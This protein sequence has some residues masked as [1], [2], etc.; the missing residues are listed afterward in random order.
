[1]EN[2]EYCTPTKLVF[3]KDCINSLPEVLEKLGKNVLLAYGGGSIKRSGLY[4]K[5]QILL[6]GFNVVELAG[7][8]PNPRYNPSVLKG[9][10]LCRENNVDVILAAGGGSVIDCAKAIAG[11]AG[12]EGDAWDII[13]GKIPTT[14]AIPIVDILTLAATGSEY[15]PGAV[16]SKTETND[17]I[18]YVNELLYPVCSFLDPAYTYTVPQN[19]TMAGIADAMNHVIEQYFAG[20]TSDLMDGMCESTLKSLMKN[21]RILLTQPQNYEARA[22]VMLACSL[23]C[24]GILSLGNSL[25]GWPLHSI[26]HVISGF[27]DIT[28][29][30]GLA[31][32]T[33]RWMKY[34]L[35]EKTLDRFVKY[36]IN[37]YGIDSRLDKWE[38]AG[39][40]ITKTHEFFASIG[41]PMHL[42]DVG[43]DESRLQEMA[44]RVID[45]P[46]PGSEGLKAAWIPLNENDVLAIL[47]ACL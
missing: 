34:V 35:S 26:E 11:C 29:G 17:K 25:S 31:I 12:T 46:L 44:K 30:V 41:I 23:A 42:K 20:S 5:I 2:F 37:I 9:V 38:I 13:T 33:P 45:T 43:I 14:G 1:M 40:A 27:Y 19:Q 24:N 18:A 10:K 22:E 36:G 21:A 32:L 6:K 16:I 3:G 4:D 8:E 7:I 47:K 39:Q 15:D 28:H